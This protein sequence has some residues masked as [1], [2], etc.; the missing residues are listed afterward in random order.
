MHNSSMSIFNENVRQAIADR[1]ITITDLAEQIG[2]HREALSKILNGRCDPTS[3]TL[4]KIA[5]GLETNLW[6]LMR[7]NTVRKRRQSQ[8]A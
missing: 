7:P 8:V 6:E 2:M 4:D 3:S 1:H 5:A